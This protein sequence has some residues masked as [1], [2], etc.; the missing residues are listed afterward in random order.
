[1]VDFH[2]ERA[3]HKTEGCPACK[4]TMNLVGDT[5]RCE[6]CGHVRQDPQLQTLIERGDRENLTFCKCGYC[7]KRRVGET[8]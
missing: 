2:A 1:M 8:S 7:L 3:A 5:Y 6:Q 4:G